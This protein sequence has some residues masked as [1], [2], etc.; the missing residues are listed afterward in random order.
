MAYKRSQTVKRV[1]Y[2]RRSLTLSHA[3]LESVLNNNDIIRRVRYIVNYSDL[4]FQGLFAHVGE[5]VSL[6]QV[7]GW[8]KRDE[9]PDFIECS[10]YFLSAFLDGLIIEKRGQKEG[11]PP[12]ESPPHLT[13]NIILR[14]LKI[15]FSLQSQEIIQILAKAGF[16][17]SKHEL[18]AFFRHPSHKHYRACQDQVLRKFLQGLTI[19]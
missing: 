9:D 11:A 19:R 13:Q 2:L 4:Q 10:D 14:K 18:S 5:R 16:R 3:Q 8:L 17:L 15:A 6:D 1:F 7:R 12:P